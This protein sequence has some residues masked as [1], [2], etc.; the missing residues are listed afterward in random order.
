MDNYK[1]VGLIG[2][3]TKGESKGIYSFTLDTKKGEIAE[4]ALV[5]E[6]DN[7]TYLALSH[8]NHFLYSVVKDGELG[9][10]AAFRVNSQNGE[11]TFINS[12]VSEGA[13]PCHVSIDNKS[14]YVLSANYHKG[15]IEAH[16]LNQ[17][18]GAILPPT[19]IIVHTGKGPD[20]RQ[21]KPHTHY[22]G[23]TPDKKFVI[24]VELGIDKIITYELLN[25]KFAQKN[26]LSV[27][28]GSGPRHITFHPNGKHAFVMTEFSSE[29][30][31]LSYDQKDGSFKQLQ[32][33]STIPENFDENNQGSAIHI[34]SDG[35]FVYAGNRGHNSIAI[36][37][38][39]E[40]TGM[41]H[42]IDHTSTEGDWPRDFTLDPTEKF[43]VAS[44]QNSGNLVLFA[45][46]E[47][48]GKLTLLQKNIVV[49]E[50]VCVKFL[51]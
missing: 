38:V 27:K 51:K 49:P 31:V 10:I 7:P 13:P 23:F 30:L 14:N 43:L 44:N 40:E 26:S 21:E 47:A 18:T 33:I 41:L 1:F 5:A 12:H 35:H 11:L 50:P 8:D 9:G 24:A 34:S 36:F 39:N 45:R 16:D 37:Q 28:P 3:Y 29:V 4:A 15:T 20:K 6:L 42:I 22:A 46:D 19:S 32:S 48:T 17:E 2:T 25:G